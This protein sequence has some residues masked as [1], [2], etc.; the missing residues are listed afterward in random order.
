MWRVRALLAPALA[1]AGR[2]WLNAAEQ[3]TIARKRQAADAQRE[4]AG[5]AA[6][7]YLLGSYLNLAPQRVPIAANEHG[8]PMVTG[9]SPAQHLEFNVSHSG[10]WVLLAFTREN[11]LGID[12]EC[13]RPV[14]FDELVRGFFSPAERAVWSG[15]QPEHKSLAFYA[16]WTR[17]EAYLKALGLGLSRALDGFTVRYAPREAPPALLWCADDPKAPERWRILDLELAP[18]YSAALATAA[19]TAFAR[20]FTWSYPGEIGSQRASEGR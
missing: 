7:R 17:K 9:L 19:T 5:R 6:L 20:G 18:G 1:E 8:K 13:H 10:E 15:L 4:L 14:E 3:Q 2:G 12:V 16:A 11:P